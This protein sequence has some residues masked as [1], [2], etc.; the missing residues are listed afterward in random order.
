[1]EKTQ[2]N[3]ILDKILTSKNVKENFAKQYADKQF[4]SY[5]ELVLPE[6]HDCLRCEVETLTGKYNLLEQILTNIEEMNKLT[7]SMDAKSKR[8]FAYAMLMKDCVKPIYQEVH[9]VKEKRVD[10]FPHYTWA[11]E[12]VS[13]RTLPKFNFSEKEIFDIKKTLRYAD[14][15]DNIALVPENKNQEKLTPEFVK[16]LVKT[17]NKFGDGTEILNKIILINTAE[18]KAFNNEEYQNKLAVIK[19][20]SELLSELSQQK[21]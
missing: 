15:F 9:F 1:M 7:S 13:E 12:T 14:V 6:V 17:L 3:E 10:K 19:K 5:L 11:S 18:C 2:Y 21:E 4:S 8:K 20:A 16:S